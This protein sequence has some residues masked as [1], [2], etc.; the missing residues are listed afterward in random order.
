MEPSHIHL[1]FFNLVDKILLLLST[2]DKICFNFADKCRS[3]MASDTHKIPLFADPFLS[4]LIECKSIFLLKI[5]LLPFLSWLDHSVLQ[6][7]TSHSDNDSVTDLLTQ[8]DSLI[9]TD[10]P[11]TAYPIPTLSKLMIPLDDNF[12]I[13]ATKA[14]CNFEKRSLN[15]ITHFKGR[16]MKL[17]KI[18]EHAIQLIAICTKLNYL[19]WIVPQCI[20]SVIMNSLH[21]SEIQYEL[22]E[23]GITMTTILP[24][25]FID[26]HDINTQQFAGGPF[27]VLSSQN[28]TV[29]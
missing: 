4:K 15:T 7:L 21:N 13:V 2:A 5:L 16:L 6:E 22:W 19:Y 23:S 17:W 14:A 18:T 10:K 11:I 28:D 25:L 29:C 3:L 12:T 26:D 9:D 8:F 1:Q 20:V 24:N 27:S